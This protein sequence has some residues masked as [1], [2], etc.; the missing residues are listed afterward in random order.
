MLFNN[1]YTNS[2]RADFILDSEKGVSGL[3]YFNPERK[4]YEKVSLNDGSFTLSFDAGE[5]KIFRLL[6]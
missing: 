4:E 2:V 3:E 6:K 1:D 5:G